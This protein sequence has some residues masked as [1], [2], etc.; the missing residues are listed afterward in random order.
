MKSKRRCETRWPMRKLHKIRKGGSQRVERYSQFSKFIQISAICGRLK[1]S[2]MNKEFSKGSWNSIYLN[3]FP[4][5]KKSTNPH[6]N[7]TYLKILM[8][9]I[10]WSITLGQHSISSQK[11]IR[12]RGRLSG[13]VLKRKIFRKFFMYINKY[14]YMSISDLFIGI[15]DL[16]FVKRQNCRLHILI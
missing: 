10:I 16:F 1:K 9:K 15:W 5:P 12:R 2:S 7:L 13:E 14:T 6:S 11:P 8:I 3:I 4:N